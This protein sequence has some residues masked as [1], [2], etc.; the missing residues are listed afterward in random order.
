MVYLDTIEKIVVII[1]VIE[2]LL[3]ISYYK[4][5]KGDIIPHSVNKKT[6]GTRPLVTSYFMRKLLQFPFV[7]LYP[8]Y[9]R[10]KTFLY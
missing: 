2:M 3:S 9:I 5:W 10:C 4:K 1:D 6:S 8:Q 7:K